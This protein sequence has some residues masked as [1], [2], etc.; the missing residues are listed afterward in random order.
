MYGPG[1]RGALVKASSGD[2]VYPTGREATMQF[3]LI[4]A[5]GDFVCRP[6]TGP[7]GMKP[8]HGTIETHVWSPSEKAGDF[9]IRDSLPTAVSRL[10]R[11]AT[12]TLS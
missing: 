1:S 4:V 10:H 9:G 3:Y 8:P 6:C 5:H 11:L 7:G 2:I 12:I